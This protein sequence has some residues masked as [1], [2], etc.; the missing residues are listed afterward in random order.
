MMP[1]SLCCRSTGV[2]V[3]KPVREENHC[4]GSFFGANLIGNLM[5][6]YLLLE[7]LPDPP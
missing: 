5:L 4:G 2:E 3:P 1:Y 7:P 6:C